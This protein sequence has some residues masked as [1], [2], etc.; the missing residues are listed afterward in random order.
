MRVDSLR[1]SFMFIGRAARLAFIAFADLLIYMAILSLFLRFGQ[2]GLGPRLFQLGLAVGL[3]VVFTNW[4]LRRRR[5]ALRPWKPLIGAVAASVLTPSLLGP[6]PVLSLMVASALA[7]SPYCLTG[8]LEEFMERPLGLSG[9]VGTCE[10]CRVRYNLILVRRSVYYFLWWGSPMKTKGCRVLSSAGN[11]YVTV[12]VT[13][14]TDE[15][16]RSKAL[17]KAYEVVRTTPGILVPA[18]ADGVRQARMKTAERA[19][20][21]ESREKMALAPLAMATKRTLTCAIAGSRGRG[22][23][24]DVLITKGEGLWRV[25]VLT[26]KEVEMTPQRLRDLLDLYHMVVAGN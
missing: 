16:C 12:A 20:C 26:G 13:A 23:A 15:G 1:V 24:A 3:P 8:R 22:T 14:F 21:P 2:D 5:R 6:I 7:A 10:D 11:E 17:A 18:G 19:P 9:M 4:A 25:K